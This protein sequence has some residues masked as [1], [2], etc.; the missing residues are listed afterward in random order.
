MTKTKRAVDHIHFE[1][2]A[3]LRSVT[4]EDVGTFAVISEGQ[5]QVGKYQGGAGAYV[6]TYEVQLIDRARNV[7]IARRTFEGGPPPQTVVGSQPGYGPYPMRE[8]VNY[9]ASLPRR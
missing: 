1:L 4:P 7:T 6:R 2:P 9:L 5:K 8:T 3:E